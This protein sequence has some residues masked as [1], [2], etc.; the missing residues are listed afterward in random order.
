MLRGTPDGSAARF[1]AWLPGNRGEESRL[2]ESPRIA[3]VGAGLAGAAAAHTLI[4]AGYSVQVFEKSRGAGGRAAT[5]RTPLGPFDHGA[6][7]LSLSREISTSPS[8]GTWTPLVGALS[9]AR[10]LL[11]HESPPRR[12]GVPGMSALV[13]ALLEGAELR[14]QARVVRLHPGSSEP[15]APPLLA[16]AEGGEQRF[17]AILLAIPAPQAAELLPP[18]PAFRG[19]R[20]GASYT[21]CWS[22]LV[23]WSEAFEIPGDL[24]EIEGSPLRLA[25]RQASRP[26]RPPGT[27]WV[28]QA[29]ASWS[30]EHLEEPPGEVAT[31][32]LAALGQA[33]E[34]HL[35]P[36]DLLQAHRWRYARVSRPLGLPFL[37]DPATGL[38]ACGDWC[39]GDRGSHALASGE[40]LAQQV[41]LDLAQTLR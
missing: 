37:W 11:F 35:P 2:S 36:P 17:D 31:M 9:P 7:Q 14:T 10:P 21:P 32:L 6:P 25:I 38:G 30:L 28:L 13:R 4:S 22:V 33:L 15:A 29:T 5:R 3:V 40:A 27:R 26:G 23:G 19:I 1:P 41:L 16:L 20:Q 12:V 34:G 18:L 8:L 24:L 39:L